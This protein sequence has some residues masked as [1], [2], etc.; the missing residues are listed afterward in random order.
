MGNEGELKNLGRE[1]YAEQQHAMQLAAK[2]CEEHGDFISTVISTNVIHGLDADDVFQ[3]FFLSLAHRPLPTY[4]RDIKSYLCRAI[5]NDIFDMVRQITRYKIF[6]QDYSEEHTITCDY[7]DPLCTVMGA[8][9]TEKLF[10]IIKKHLSKYE[11]QVVIQRSYYD[12]SIEEIAKEMNISKR[13]VSH[14][15][16]TGLGKL[17]E[18][19]NE[20]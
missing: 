8:E 20:Y 2:I 11:T 19:I 1:A 4:I 15:L 16:C 17:R 12:K 6:I 7:D 18:L 14:Y 9:Q 3:K 13:S 5:K 10:K